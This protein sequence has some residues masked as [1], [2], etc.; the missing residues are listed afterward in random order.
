[1]ME[2]PGVQWNRD[3]LRHDQSGFEVKGSIL[4]RGVEREVTMHIGADLRDQDI[5]NFAGNLIDRM[6]DTGVV[7]RSKGTHISELKPGAHVFSYGTGRPGSKTF[8]V[9]LKIMDL[10]TRP[11]ATGPEI[12]IPSETTRE[13]SPTENYIRATLASQDVKIGKSGTL[14][15]LLIAGAAVIDATRTDPSIKLSGTRNAL[16][17]FSELAN[18]WKARWQGGTGMHL[19]QLQKLELLT[20]LVNRTRPSLSEF[21]DEIYEKDLDELDTS[22]D[23]LIAAVRQGPAEWADSFRDVEDPTRVWNQALIDGKGVSVPPEADKDSFF[24][25]LQLATD[26]IDPKTKEV[27]AYA[28]Q[29]IRPQDMQNFREH[30]VEN[31]RVIRPNADQLAENGLQQKHRALCGEAEYTFSDPAL[32]DG[33]LVVLATVKVGSESFVRM[34]YQS[35]SQG[36][37][38]S[39]HGFLPGGHI[40]KGI[41][42][43]DTALPIEVNLA[44]NA[45]V[46]NKQPFK[47]NEQ[48][49]YRLALQVA[50]PQFRPKGMRPAFWERFI[51]A[52]PTETYVQQVGVR[53][54]SAAQS[55]G[56]LG[57][58][59]Q[60][61]FAQPS[62]SQRMIL[63]LYGEVAARVFPSNNGELNYL[64]YET[65]RGEVWIGAI[66][67]AKGD[68]AQVTRYGVR[69]ISP[70][71]GE[72]ERLPLFEYHEQIGRPYVPPQG[73]GRFIEGR[74]AAN[75]AYGYNWGAVRNLPVIQAY[76]AYHRH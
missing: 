45:A 25:G 33:R 5:L 55:Q 31:I 36:N 50:R 51:G 59:L 61:N 18:A 14:D 8:N 41:S 4:I 71:V 75:P 3:S 62:S 24:M 72:A 53:Q 6:R 22:K 13:D 15:K 23:A 9:S 2:G 35:Q 49:M 64:F 26:V 73:D 27:L 68:G 37:W 63:P 74:L 66:E 47:P 76:L 1:M 40:A 39:L 11:A 16:D 58:E 32:Y 19:K 57:P 29:Q 48:F 69:A 65:D 12:D 60:P 28:G 42:E 21:D 17:K 7:S 43:H 20:V 46:G 70:A 52:N 56:P 44:I 54:V 30:N 67:L 34:F 38:R 10:V